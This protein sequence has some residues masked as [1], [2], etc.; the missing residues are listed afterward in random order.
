MN[1]S[2][3]APTT[4]SIHVVHELAESP[5]KVWRALVEPE[6]LARWLMPNDFLPEVGREFTFRAPPMGDWD[7]VV[8][9]K[10]LEIV[11]L[12]LVRWSWKGGPAHSRLDTVLTITL[13]PTPSGGTRLVLDHA[14]FV[15]ANAFAY[16]IMG[17]GWR[18]KVL[19][20]IRATIA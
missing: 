13:S 4:K 8:Q 14:G 17:K 7:G 6:L 1:A 16:E 5:A 19:E 15:E 18:E 3:P 2:Q 9:C 10:V 11:P 12:E 20:R